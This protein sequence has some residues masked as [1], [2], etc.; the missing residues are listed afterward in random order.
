MAVVDIAIEKIAQSVFNFV[1]QRTGLKEKLEDKLGLDARKNAFK[2][3]FAEAYQEFAAQH[4]AEVS[5][6]FDTSFFEREGAPILAQLLIPGQ[7]PDPSE[8]ADRWARSLNATQ[9]ERRA[10][11]VREMEPVAA[12][13]LHK[14]SARLMAQ[15]E[16]WEIVDSRAFQQIAEILAEIDR[17][18][19]GGKATYGTRQ[20]Y[21]HWLIERNLYLDPRG[22]LQT[23]R[24]VQVKLEEVY[25]S[26]SAQREES[27]GTVV[28]RRLLEH[29]MA[30]FQSRIDKGQVRGEEAEDER[31]LLLSRYGKRAI[32]GRVEPEQAVDLAK[33]VTQQAK[34][35][36][37]GDPGSGK[38]TLLR[39]LALKHAQALWNGH[40]EVDA[41]LGPARFPVLIRIA[42]YAESGAWKDKSL[43][44]FLEQACALH[45]CP[46]QGLR[47]LVF[48]RLEE[49][50][51]LVLL[52]GLDEIVSAD[53]R[54]AIVGRVEDFVRRYDDKANRFIVTSRLAGYHSSPLAEPFAHYIVRDMGIEQI[55]L[56][57]RRWCPAV[58]AETAELSVQEREAKA[59]EEIDT[60]ME[61][62]KTNPGVKRLAA[63]PLMLRTLALI[64]RTGKQLPRKRIEL[65]K[66]AADTLARTWRISQ[67]IAE[68]ALVQ[69]E[70]LTPM[71][72]ALAYWMHSNKDTGIATEKEVMALLGEVWA[73]LNGLDWREDK[74]NPKIEAE[75][76]KFLI[77]VREHTGLFVLRAPN[78]YG[79]MHLTF[80]EYYAAR[81]LVAQSSNRAK[82]IRD[83]LHDQRWNEPILLALGFVGLESSIEA[84]VLLE[85]AILAEGEMAK[86]FNFAPSEYEDVLGRDFLFALRCLGDSIPMHPKLIERL[87]ERLISETVYEKNLGR[88]PTYKEKL[89]E[90][91]S[92]LGGTEITT[93]MREKLIRMCLQRHDDPS[94]RSRVARSLGRAAQSS[95]EVIQA[96]LAA[97][98]D[99]DPSVRSSAARSL[100]RVAQSSP[101][102]IQ[103]LLAALK[104][105]D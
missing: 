71:L 86:T 67:G 99:D 65:Y 33:V 61:A 94:V 20:D 16:L 34:L 40:K 83:H 90:R 36:I 92:L 56:F 26:L 84:R 79:F 3:A 10:R 72:S 6:L 91:L 31:E 93:I 19:T 88:L 103:A 98:K 57:L 101:E 66:L 44:D 13:F 54:R 75:I 70:Y 78:R 104:D 5:E 30:Q 63:N 102:V 4:P 62:V 105:D 82:L 48:T 96:L 69:D 1:L 49:G 95:P 43:G 97:L 58:E 35:V 39:F 74:P 23:Q 52:D 2:L 55:E 64:H 37:L 89:N 51:C 85:A 24:Q 76:K 59:N 12:N 29:E 27:P 53:D 80:E 22:T 47:D 25:V 21:L 8:L 32:E 41:E 68:S 11:Y 73:D 46:S 9:P 60:I 87:A 42:D 50:N 15:S 77:A 17:R 100:E 81:H 14:L 7:T 18:I 28:D 45:A 38:S